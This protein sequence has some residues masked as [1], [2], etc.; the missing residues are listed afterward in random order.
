M[1]SSMV[2]GGWS[3]GLTVVFAG[4][5][6]YCVWRLATRQGRGIEAVVDVNHV[7]M[8]PAMLVMLWWPSAPSGRWVQVALFAGMAVLFFRHLSGSVTVPVRTGALLHGGM[9]LAMVWMLVAMPTLMPTMMEMAGM[10]DHQMAGQV[11]GM[12]SWTAMLS[13]V[14]AGLMLIAA[15]WWAVRALRAHGHRLLC[16][17]HALTCAGMTAMLALTSPAL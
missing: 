12:Q 5:G 13:W 10:E 4:V 17:C 9:N 14:V 16:G 1:S 6:L 2:P 15:G 3:V 8:S 7:L 11:V